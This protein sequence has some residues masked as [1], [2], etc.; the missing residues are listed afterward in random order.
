MIDNTDKHASAPDEMSSPLPRSIV[1]RGSDGLL[2]SGWV[3]FVI[4]I[5]VAVFLE[6]DALQ[7]SPGWTTMWESVTLEVAEALAKGQALYPNLQDGPIRPA[8]Y[9]PLYYLLLALPGAVR[10]MGPEELAHWGRMLSII[11]LGIAL[12]AAVRLTYRTTRSPVVALLGMGGA[13]FLTPTAIRFIASARPDALAAAFS[14]L[15]LLVA[16]GAGKHRLWVVSI[17]LTAAVQTKMTSVSAGLVILLAMAITRQWQ[18]LTRLVMITGI[19]NAAIWAT[20]AWQSGG[21]VLDHV[22]MVTQVPKGLDYTWYMLTRGGMP[23]ALMLLASL[24]TMALL[25]CLLRFSMMRRDLARTEDR[26]P[27]STI[28]RASELGLLIILAYFPMSAIIA[29]L[30]AARLGSDRNYLIE[31]ALAAGPL[32]GLFAYSCRR[33]SSTKHYVTL[34]LLAVFSLVITA[35][36]LL[37]NRTERFDENARWT[38]KELTPY[39]TEAIEWARDLEQPLL[40]LD[41]WL[42]FKADIPNDLTGP[43]AYVSHLKGSETKDV[44]SE[45]AGQRY[46]AAIVTMKPIEDGPAEVYRHIEIP[47]PNLIDSITNRYAHAEQYKGWH[48]YRPGEADEPTEPD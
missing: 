25:L 36:W 38:Y 46:Y 23:P 40:C 19:L 16:V 45:R 9:G 21:S 37:P 27:D 15:A 8:I 42:A 3:C 6:L 18:S 39:T 29:L 28:G 12:M 32:I 10:E 13:L 34:R 30:T 44:T 2:V 7:A 14:M 4:V 31:P 43:I 1:S 33:A 5:L 11:S 35:V 26:E 22:R 47:W 24:P 20:L 17:L 41:S 48:V